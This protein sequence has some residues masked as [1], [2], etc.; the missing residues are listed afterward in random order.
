MVP[1]SLKIA[2]RHS[3]SINC[4]CKHKVFD[5]MNHEQ[6]SIQLRILIS[7]KSNSLRIK[8]SQF[9]REFLGLCFILTSLYPHVPAC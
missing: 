9:I 5:N 2:G 6:Q 4:S 1:Y 8:I 7:R 3:Q